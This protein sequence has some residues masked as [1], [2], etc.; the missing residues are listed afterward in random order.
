MAKSSA[1]RRRR[2]ADSPAQP[3]PA[4][5]IVAGLDVAPAA[6]PEVAAVLGGAT[7]LVRPP[8]GEQPDD[9]KVPGV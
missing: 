7:V 1:S 3:A 8:A 9:K 5:T 6:A 2:P 4:D